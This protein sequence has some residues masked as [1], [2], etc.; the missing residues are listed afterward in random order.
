MTKGIVGA[1]SLAA[2]VFF[3]VLALVLGKE[4]AWDFQNYHWYTPYA[5]LNGRRMF[6]IAVAHHATYYSPLLDLPLW[7]IANAGP[8]WWGGVW[9]GLHAG[10]SA[11]LIA[12]IAWHVL[13][14]HGA[15]IRLAVASLLGFFG[16]LG[17]GTM[18][19]I[20]STSND[21]LVGLPVLAS[22]L[23][24]LLAADCKRWW[25]LLLAGVL[26]GF[27]VGAKLTTGIYAVGSL[28]ALLFLAGGPRAKLRAIVLFGLGGA[29]GAAIT[30]GFWW[31][32]LWRETGNPLFPFANTI[33][34]SPLIKI[35]DYS[36]PTFRPRDWFTRI[37][38]PFIF[39]T[40]SR[41]VAEWDFR[42]VRIAVA[43][44]LAFVM[45]V[46]MVAKRTSA[47]P[48]AD[49]VRGRML[50]AYVAGAYLPWALVFGIYRY[51]LPIEMLAPVAI[52]VLIGWTDAPRAARVATVVLLTVM[53]Q[54]M[55]SFSLERASFA[56]RYVEVQM[57]PLEPDAMVLG[58]GKY[59]Y[60]YVIPSAPP[61]VPWLRIDG[62]LVGPKDGTGLTAILEERVAAHRGPLYVIFSD[63][64]RNYRD[65]AL[66]AYGL[67]ADDASCST[68]TSNIG[69]P[70]G[71]CRV[72]RRG[73]T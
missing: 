14:L 28:G 49:R 38:F 4:A 55:V 24:L 67:D 70:L 9:L 52:A 47:D 54:A 17:G 2:L 59:P 35:A 27:A 51:A 64:E 3:A 33:F 19:Q 44:V 50:L 56:G 69:R 26:C 61:S 39:T 21:I 53:T 25:M 45:L 5:L 10:A 23:V 11:I 66:A 8:G 73:S 57:Q 43:Y 58:T 60:S 37:L 68:V 20:G 42:D 48:L 62:W 31:Y 32:A 6:D 22:L 72:V 16:A 30:G 41:K 46:A 40:D 7:W 18:S 65:Q 71:L 29:I 36:D 15:T 34:K 63:W 12:A 13:P 1:L